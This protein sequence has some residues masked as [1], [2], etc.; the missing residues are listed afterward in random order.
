MSSDPQADLIYAILTM[1]FYNRGYG[2]GIAGLD[3]MSR[4][5]TEA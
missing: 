5:E 4:I 2:S 1:D 3:R